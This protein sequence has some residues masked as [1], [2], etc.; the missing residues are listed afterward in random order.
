MTSGQNKAPARRAKAFSKART[1]IVETDQRLE[2]TSRYLDNTR[3]ELGNRS[4]ELGSLKDFLSNPIIEQMGET[5]KRD[6]GRLLAAELVDHFSTLL[7]KQPELFRAF[8]EMGLEDMSKLGNNMAA[9]ALHI[10]IEDKMQIDAKAHKDVA[11]RK[12]TAYI[13]V[14]I[15]QSNFTVCRSVREDI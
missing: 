9:H 3:R 10:L 11:E 13:Q 14:H 15:P 5:F 2:T 7:R 12:D 4:Q 1:R 8:V 6:L